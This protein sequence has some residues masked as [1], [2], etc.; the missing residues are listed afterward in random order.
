MKKTI[1]LVGGAGYIGPVIAQNLLA[2]GY[3]VTCLDLFIYKNNNCVTHL[4]NDDNFKFIYG[5]FRNQEVLRGA[6]KGVSDVVI[7]G[8]LV[9]DPITKKYQHQ[10]SSINDDGILACIDSLDG[11]GLNKV[12]FVS[13]CSNY[14]LIA[15]DQL[16]D[17]LFPLNPLSLYA[18]SKVAAELLIMSKKGVVDYSPV[19]FRFATAFG[20]APRMRFDL[21]VN[22]FAR[23]LALGRELLVFD[24]HTWRPYCHVKDFARLINLALEAPVS[25]VG[26]EIFNAGGAMNNFTKQGILDKI[27]KQLPDAKIRY[28][29]NSADPRNYRVKFDKVKSVLGFE[30]M[31]SVEYGVNEIITAIKEHI[32]DLV[33]DN[34]NFYGNYEIDCAIK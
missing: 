13:T 10:S 20:L 9:G 27:L 16:A 4:L 8:G 18:K 24:A 2:C 34:T 19:I 1:L 32:F 30:P 11:H 12:V 6:L 21:T 26:F 25:D 28:Q 5:D 23:E 15:E 31:Y 3:N 22:E 7:L 33:D 17:E 14:G 29:E